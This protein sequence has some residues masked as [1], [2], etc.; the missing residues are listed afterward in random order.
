MMSVMSLT[1]IESN[2]GM[3]SREDQM[4]L[5]ERIIHRL[6]KMNLKE[7]NN[8][9]SQ[10]AAMAS[11]R[12]IQRELHNIDEEFSIAESDGLGEF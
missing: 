1:Q 9:E 6:R 12:E 10:L 7:K 4:L 2:I 5:L 8:L 11:D 3:L